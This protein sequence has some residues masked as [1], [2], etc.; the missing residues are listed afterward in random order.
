MATCGPDNMITINKVSACIILLGLL[1][2][3]ATY[4]DLRN[5]PPSY[6]VT[7]NKTVNQ[8]AEC[9]LTKLIN[10]HASAH[11]IKDRNSSI[12][13][14]PIGE[15]WNGG[16]DMSMIVVIRPNTVQLMHMK[17]VNSFHKEWMLIQ[18]CL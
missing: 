17:S 18:P 14:V 3:C 1:T 8:I 13:V 2:G 15:Q 7:S 5:K 10:I 9:S 6:V 11:I 16:N 12:I 4:S